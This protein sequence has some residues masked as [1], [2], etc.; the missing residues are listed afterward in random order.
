MKRG[1]MTGQNTVRR[2][3]VLVVI[4]AAYSL[5]PGVYEAR[6]QDE[7]AKC[8]ICHNRADAARG[9]LYAGFY[10]DFKGYLSSVHGD[11]SCTSC[12]Q[13]HSENPHLR[14][15]ENLDQ[16]IVAIAAQLK[17]LH[18]KDAYALAACTNCH[19]DAFEQFRT[20]VHGVELFE[21]HSG[22]VAYCT[23]CHGSPHYIKPKTDPTSATYYTNVPA[24]CGKCHG[25][26][27]IISKYKLNSHVLEGYNESF[28]GKKLILG[29]SKVAVCTSCHGAHAVVSPRDS[30]RFL[31]NLSSV[32]GRCH[33]GATA[34]FA[35]AFTHI[36]ISQRQTKIVYRTEK[37][38]GLLL[39]FVMVSL[40]GHVAL[41]MGAN[42]REHSKRR[43][44]R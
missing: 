12:H 10:V 6:G 33:E 17:P 34:K 15:T 7:V 37:F 19:Y 35:Q 13:S 1:A 5:L 43:K 23:K 14:D 24:M 31:G 2:C 44:G 22:D 42:I 16:S 21:K 36:P 4:L 41:D 8:A 32:C 3:L 38:F 27:E 20:S 39:V 9:D 28:H 25:D 11:L 18:P 29:S 40:V 26:S 30:E